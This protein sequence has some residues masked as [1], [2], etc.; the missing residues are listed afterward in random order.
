MLPMRHLSY[1]AIRFSLPDMILM[2][3]EFNFMF[4]YM[5][6]HHHHYHHYFSAS[7]MF[8]A[9]KLNDYMLEVF[10]NHAE[11]FVKKLDSVKDFEV[12]DIQVS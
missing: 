9:K 10:V 6:H 11:D 7:H 8:S 5:H 4:D 1:Y 2:L 12:I 3:R